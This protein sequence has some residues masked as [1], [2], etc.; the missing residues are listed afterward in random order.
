MSTAGSIEQALQSGVDL[1]RLFERELGELA[2]TAGPASVPVSKAPA[3]VLLNRVPP[4]YTAVLVNLELCSRSELRSFLHNQLCTPSVAAGESGGGPPRRLPLSQC[5][6]QMLEFDHQPDFMFGK[7]KY[8]GSDSAGESD[9]DADHGPDGIDEHDADGY[10]QDASDAV[11]SVPDTCLGDEPAEPT[12]E[13]AP[14]KIEIKRP[15]NA[16]IIFRSEHHSEAVKRHRGGNKVVSKIL[17]EAW[18]ALPAEEK[19]RYKA[20]A[21]TRKREHELLYPNYR[22][23]PRKRRS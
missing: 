23:A 16:F 6:C 19:K 3:G 21:A 10:V 20:M 1:S 22:F 5:K 13:A 4:G 8:D 17:A 7:A 12:P 18:R 11:D 2:L 9:D 15:P 14:N